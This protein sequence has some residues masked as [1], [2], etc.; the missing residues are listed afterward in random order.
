MS[1]KLGIETN[2]KKLKKENIAHTSIRLDEVLW[3]EIKAKA[4]KQDISPSTLIAMMLVKYLDY[5]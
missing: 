4:A 2:E 1:I 3:A 5:C